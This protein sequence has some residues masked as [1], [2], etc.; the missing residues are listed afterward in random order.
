MRRYRNINYLNKR[1]R[2]PILLDADVKAWANRV[3]N[4]GGNISIP[5]IKAV[6]TFMT[7]LKATTIRGKI[8]RLNLFCGDDLKSVAVPLIIDAGATT[9]NLVNYTAASYAE[10]LGI[11]GNGSTQYIDTGYKVTGGGSLMNTGS[12]HITAYVKTHVVENTIDFSAINGGTN[13]QL[14]AYITY[15]SNISYWDCPIG[16]RIN[17]ADNGGTGQYSYIRTAI[18]Q[19]KIRNNKADVVSGNGAGGGNLANISQNIYINVQNI[20]NAPQAGTY[21]TKTFGSYSFGGG[22][23]DGEA[24][25]LDNLIQAFQYSLGRHV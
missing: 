2:R 13:D 20:N 8:D 24:D 5:T 7:R 4:N 9:D 23:L 11:K 16:N 19:A 6:N 10:N 22:L 18:N 21:G 25:E 3:F 15:L 14:G 17:G 1:F 12:V